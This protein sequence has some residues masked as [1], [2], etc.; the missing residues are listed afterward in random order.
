MRPRIGIA[1][2]T[3]PVEM[4]FGRVEVYGTF[5]PYVDMVTAAGGL[6]LVLPLAGP[7]Y[8]PAVVQAVDALILTG[9]PDLADTPR[10]RTEFALAT[11]ALAARLP[12][13]GICRGLQVLNVVTGG[14]PHPHVDG[15]LGRDVRHRVDV[16]PGSTLASLVGSSVETGSL[17][18][19]AADRIG[20]G[21]RPIAWSPDGHVEAIEAE[22]G[23]PVL[24]VQWH[25]E[26]EP[27]PV[28]DALITWLVTQA[29]SRESWEGPASR[30]KIGSQ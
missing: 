14:S 29:L 19:Q 26:L 15:H 3:Y 27:G 4:P 13:L 30:Q 22:D 1:G 24:A 2:P 9:G 28:T 23:S 5:T 11:A 20:A 6:P 12:V 7:E 17:H 25:P 16:A 18:H 21:L 10:D 8:A